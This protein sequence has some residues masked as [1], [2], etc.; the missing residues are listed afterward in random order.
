L[1]DSFFLH[2]QTAR[3]ILVD[4]AKAVDA[5]VD[6]IEEALRTA[7]HVSSWGNFALRRINR[8]KRRRKKIPVHTLVNTLMGEM[9]PLLL[10]SE[11]KLTA[12]VKEVEG[13]AFGMDVESVLVNLITNAY[14]FA[15]L[16]PRNRAVV[17]ELREKAH[18]G[19]AGFEL[20]VRD[21]GPGIDKK[22]HGAHL[23][24]A[25]H[26]QSGRAGRPAGTGLGLSIVQ[27]VVNDLGG[28]RESGPDEELGGAKFT[29]WLPLG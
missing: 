1:I 27:S 18:D 6:E 3:N 28:K 23:G 21:S 22:N 17:V 7:E 15:K 8:D 29:V 24:S 16:K 13:R 14:Y 11:V 10:Q 4:D 5:A 9:T 2:A 12:K 26:N 19:T 25:I 20:T